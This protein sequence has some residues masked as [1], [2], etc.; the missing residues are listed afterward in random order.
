MR[1][2]AIPARVLTPQRA[3]VFLATAVLATIVALTIGV[4]TAR[5]AVTF[6]GSPGTGAPPATLGP[7]TMTQFANDPVAVGS[8]VSS[9]PAPVGS[10][11]FSPSLTNAEIGNGWA[12]WSH[13][14]T[15]DVYHNVFAGDTD[16]VTMTLPAGTVAFYFYAEPLVFATFDI[17]ATTDSGATS[18]PVAVEGQAGAKYFGFYATG[19]D[20]IATIT[21]TSPGAGGFAVGEFGIAYNQAPDC[22]GVV[23][24]KTS[25]WPPNHK[26]QN[27]ALSGLTDPDGDPV[28]LMITG[29]TQDEPVNG[30]EDGDTAPDAVAGATPSQVKLRAERSGLGDGRV[31]EIRFTGTDAVGATCTGRVRV[32]VPLSQ[33]G[34]P[35][36]NSGQLYDS[37]G[38]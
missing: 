25:L 33:N 22:S 11:G 23:A 13:G 3:F 31:Y 26:L 18:G 10:V 5:A 14:Y 12:T 7:Y 8:T 35:A 32:S 4:G 27:I 15:G 16:T 36:V 37:F 20:S 30:L 6:D 19:G 34:D 9:A 2:L 28:T 38:P 21:V 17:T 24:D 29:V 1:Q